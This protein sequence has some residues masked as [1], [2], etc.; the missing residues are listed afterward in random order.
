MKNRQH[1]QKTNNKM[2]DIGPNISIMTLYVSDLNIL[3]I[4]ISRVDLK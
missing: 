2:S 3:I 4:K 1:K